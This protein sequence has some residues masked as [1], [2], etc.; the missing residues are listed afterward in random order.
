[1]TYK[2]KAAY[3]TP[4]TLWNTPSVI[5]QIPKGEKIYIIQAPAEATRK[6]KKVRQVTEES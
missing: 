1:M 6:M 2:V 3:M 4:K 5:P